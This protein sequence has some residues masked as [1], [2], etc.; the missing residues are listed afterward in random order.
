MSQTSIQCVPTHKRQNTL[1][2]SEY[3]IDE[4]CVEIT[5]CRYGIYPLFFLSKLEIS[6]I[7]LMRFTCVKTGLEA[8]ENESASEDVEE[9]GEADAKGGDEY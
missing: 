6:Y 1:S 9:E 2:N 5:D 7:Y 4:L 8:E 3:R